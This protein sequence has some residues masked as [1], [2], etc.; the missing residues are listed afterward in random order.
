MHDLHRGDLVVH[1]EFGIGRFNG[2][3]TIQVQGTSH[4]VVVLEYRDAAR[5]NVHVSAVHKVHKYSGREGSE[6]QISSLGSGE[7]ARKKARTKKRLK[8]ITNELIKLYARRQIQEARASEVDG[9]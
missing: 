8:D 7:W 5:L 6:A 9:H 1:D 3:E 4:E 2:F